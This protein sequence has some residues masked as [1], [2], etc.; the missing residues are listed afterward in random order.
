MNG[1]INATSSQTIEE[2]ASDT[3]VQ[4]LH[5]EWTRADQAAFE[6]RLERDPAYADAYRRVDQSWAALET[7][8]ES[9]EVMS[10]REEAIVYARKASAGR[11]LKVSAYTRNRRRL[12]AAAAGIALVLGLA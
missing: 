11:W 3:F 12:A 10:Y 5:G 8:A 2:E 6:A 4:R 1:K 9:P 7:H